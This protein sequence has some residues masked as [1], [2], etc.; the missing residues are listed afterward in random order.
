MFT[1]EIEVNH[2][3]SFVDM[4]T[5]REN[6]K[7]TTSVYHKPT[8]SRV[9][10]NFESFFMPKSYKYALIFTL[11]HRTFKLCSKFELFHQEIENLEHF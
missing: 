4:K 7:F 10:I 8:F 5:V 1:S 6:S 11:L 2:L 9:F 3:L